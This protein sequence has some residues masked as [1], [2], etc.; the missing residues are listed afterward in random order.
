MNP[1]LQTLTS[2]GWKNL[3]WEVVPL[4]NRPIPPIIIQCKVYFL[5]HKQ[6]MKVKKFHALKCWLQ[7]I[8]VLVLSGIFCCLSDFWI[9]NFCKRFASSHNALSSNLATYCYNSL[10]AC[11]FKTILFKN[12]NVAEKKDRHLLL[13]GRIP[14]VHLS[15]IHQPF[16]H[17]LFYFLRRWAGTHLYM[18]LCIYICKPHIWLGFGIFSFC[19]GFL[20]LICSIL[21]LLWADGIQLQPT[22]IT[23][24]IIITHRD[25]PLL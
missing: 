19:L 21:V 22:T 16:L 8:L 7:C 23:V 15:L 6:N 5:H 4:S 9:L 18:C 25:Y 11:F 1:F 2:E 13:V 12:F 17:R 24:M 10:F 14:T 3:C 20:H